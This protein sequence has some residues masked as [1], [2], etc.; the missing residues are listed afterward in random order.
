MKIT[1]FTTNEQ[2][3][4]IISVNVAHV[5]M[6]ERHELKVCFT[7]GVEQ[8][9]FIEACIKHYVLFSC[10]G[11]FVTLPPENKNYQRVRFRFDNTY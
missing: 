7:S 8:I 11:N 1:L 2:C 5:T 9:N 4:D 10:Q 3:A 6:F